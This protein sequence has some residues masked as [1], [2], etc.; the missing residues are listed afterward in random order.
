MAGPRHDPPIAPD[1]LTARQVAEQ[2]SMSVR[3]LYRMAARGR[4]PR[5][6]RLGRKLIRWRRRDVE[7]YV[8]QLTDLL[9]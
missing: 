9:E 3:T 6:V 7:R 5:P 8:R 1:L 2:L 4:A